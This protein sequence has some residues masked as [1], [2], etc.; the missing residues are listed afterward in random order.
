MMV[1]SGNSKGERKGKVRVQ[2]RYVYVRELKRTKGCVR[3]YVL[4]S[5]IPMT[6]QRLLSDPPFWQTTLRHCFS[7]FAHDLKRNIR[8]RQ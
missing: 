8:T 4:T 5:T 1:W 6:F 7:T 3:T 2:L